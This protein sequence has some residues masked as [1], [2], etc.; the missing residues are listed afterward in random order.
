MSMSS[1][2]SEI[3]VDTTMANGKEQPSQAA[4]AAAA[5]LLDC[6]GRVVA[7]SARG[8]ALRRAEGVLELDPSGRLHAARPAD[9]RALQ[10]ALAKAEAEPGLAQS[11]VQLLSCRSGR[12]WLAWIEPCCPLVREEARRRFRPTDTQ[13]AAAVLVLVTPANTGPSV[14]AQAI[15][16]AFSLSAAEA[17]LVRALIA[18][19]TLAEYAGAT[20]HSRHTVRNQLTAVF[21]KTGTH[22][23]AELVALIVG[24]LAPA[25]AAHSQAPN[26]AGGSRSSLTKGAAAIFRA[27]V[28][29]RRQ[30]GG[31]AAGIALSP[32]TAF[33]GRMLPHDG[34]KI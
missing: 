34:A 7:A 6:C 26:P 2:G 20:G 21:E 32:L 1:L 24:A 22:R 3:T 10:A 33:P 31:D 11:P 30:C 17:R 23:Q 27:E 18:G 4:F 16:A 13:P 9:D 12:A 5:F 25:G 19:R 15:S 14:P 28:E 29:P 8:E